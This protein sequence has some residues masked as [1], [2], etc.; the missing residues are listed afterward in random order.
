MRDLKPIAV[1]NVSLEKGLLSER[2]R[3]IREEVIPYQWRALND[4]VPHAEPSH[5]M[6]NL[7]IAAGEGEGVHRGF[8]FQDSDLAKWLEAVGYRLATHPDPE[9][10]RTADEAIAL[11]ARAQEADGYLNSYY[12]I[13]KPD[14]RWTNLRDD[15][16]LYCAGHFIEAAV[17]YYEGTGKRELLDIVCR[18]VDLIDSVFGLEP[19]K[20]KGYPGHQEIE[21]ALVRLYSVTADKKHLNLA[22]FFID[23][24][25]QE[26]HYFAEEAQKRGQKSPYWYTWGHEY[27]QSHLPVR[28]Q[29]TAVGHSVRA[30]YMYSAMVD[31]AKA[32]N[33]PGLL[34]ASKTLWQN[35]VSKRM[36]ITGG[37][38]SQE[39]G[40]GFS[41]D[42]DLPSDTA[43]TETCAAIGL[44]FWA[45]RLLQIE[46]RGE[47]GDVLESA[48][49]NGVLSGI[50]L[51]GQRFFYVNPLEVVP[52][53]IARR[54]DHSHVRPTRQSWFGCACCPPNIARLVA[55]IGRYMYSTEGDSL[56]VHL[57]G[58]S[59]ATVEIAGTNL[60]IRQETEY[61][62]AGQIKFTVTAEQTLDAT[63]Y[64]RIP[65]WCQGW[66]LRVNGELLTSP[67][68]EDGYLK[69]SRPWNHGDSVELSLE[70]PIERVRSNP[71]VR[72]TMGKVA[73][74]R[75]P[76]V[77]CLEET[78]NG[79]N[80]SALFLSGEDELMVDFDQDLGLPAIIGY[81][82]RLAS[83]TQDLYTTEEPEIETVQIKAIPYFAWDNRKPGEML[84]WLGESF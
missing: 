26:P 78:D 75:G 82:K 42:Y 65:G 29:T 9:L 71:L 63:F 56:Y 70:M 5:A 40:E 57:Y 73:L 38:G 6:E 37:L 4:E 13:M 12:T 33:D 69:L 41:T 34:E 45:H 10:E 20:L 77:Y 15:H 53:I 39:F 64:L 27:N 19:G 79:E 17:A 67:A 18:F 8:V 23:Q 76:L 21:L 3:V 80:L 81:A 28:Q 74:R 30:M 36:Y 52:E 14:Q 66:S 83:R 72:E 35:V 51:D 68:I 7:R 2:M 16:E 25:G 1:K 11:L 31:L 47:Y 46:P 60:G 61:P 24:R 50:S 22:K 62:F 49:F 59:N 55:S 32:A 84:V 44:V 58:D 43:Y 54:K 48:L